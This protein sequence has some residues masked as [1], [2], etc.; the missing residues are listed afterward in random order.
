MNVAIIGCGSIGRKRAV[1]CNALGHDIVAVGD[2]MR[3]KAE[4]IAAQFGVKHCYRGTDRSVLSLEPR[5]D[6]YII[7]TPHAYLAHMAR[8][9]ASR[10]AHVFVEKPGAR[11]PEDLCPAY[12]ES[13]KNQSVVRV[14]YSLRYHPG[15][16]QAKA[17]LKE[18]GRIMYCKGYYGHGG[19]VGY[20]Q[21]WRMNRWLSGGGVGMDLMPHL[22]DLCRYFTGTE[23]T[24]K[25]TSGATHFWKAP[26]EDNLMLWLD[27]PVSAELCASW[28]EWRN[29]FQF[30][31]VGERGKIVI[32]GI[33]GSYGV[34]TATLMIMGPE[35]GPPA[36][37]RCDYPQQDSSFKVELREFFEDIEQGRPTDCGIMEAQAVLRI[38][39]EAGAC[40]PADA[41]PQT[42]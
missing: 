18:I 16:Q 39:E 1:A 36:I 33:G 25:A 24:V 35:M 13:V 19:R 30:E 29:K 20:E 17:W 27:G 34:E 15:I 42:A 31:I 8:C 2:I 38:L 21:E 22:V 10:G 4:I 6:A 41:T 28:T 37:M 3:T 26:V 23:Y 12:A 9:A 40:I 14:G 32:D 7:S 11:R 5:P